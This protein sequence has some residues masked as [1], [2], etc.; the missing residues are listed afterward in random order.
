[1]ARTKANWLAG[2][3]R[4]AAGKAAQALAAAGTILWH[5][6]DPELARA[7]G[8]LHAALANLRNA[9][10]RFERQGRD[11]GWRDGDGEALR[12]KIELDKPLDETPTVEGRVTFLV[13][14]QGL[15]ELR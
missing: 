1:M 8:D 12:R 9:A 10:A 6:D 15:G 2:D 7:A 4:R 11:Y 14:E 13:R 3:T 5:Y